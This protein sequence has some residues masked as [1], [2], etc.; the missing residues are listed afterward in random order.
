HFVDAGTGD[1]DLTFTIDVAEHLGNTS[2]IYATI[3][4]S[5]LVDLKSWKI[6]FR[7][8]VLGFRFREG[9]C[10]RRRK[11]MCGWREGRLSA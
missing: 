5:G 11:G 6:L 7:L 8:S 10:R 3:G 2:Y 9:A 4:P 1:A